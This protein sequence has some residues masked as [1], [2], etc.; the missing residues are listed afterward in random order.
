MRLGWFI[1]LC[2]LGLG[3]LGAQVPDSGAVG[4]PTVPDTVAVIA[5]TGVG[6]ALAPPDTATNDS[7]R[8]RY[9]TPNCLPN[10]RRA[11][12]YGLA[13]PGGGQLYNRSYWKLPI[14]YG[15][16]GTTVGL[17]LW[18]N[19]QYVTWNRAYRATVTEVNPTGD[20]GLRTVRDVY[21]RNRDFWII[22]TTLGY[23]LTSVEAYV[24]AHLQGFNINPELG[25]APLPATGP[26]ARWVPTAGVTFTFR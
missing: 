25:L 5:D 11:W 20:A 13:F 4:S 21:R 15:A 16:L 3:Q 8:C 17:A 10:P 26:A 23:L 24:D 7:V 12:Q 9:R 2:V 22:L 19:S 6:F 1:G 14:V 18:Q